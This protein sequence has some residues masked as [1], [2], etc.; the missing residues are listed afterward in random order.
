[1]ANSHEMHEMLFFKVKNIK[2]FKQLQF[3]TSPPPPP[4]IKY[5]QLYHFNNK[6]EEK[7]EYMI[8]NLF[9]DIQTQ[10]S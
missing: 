5:V 6:T 9:D 3:C 2:A 4:P 7:N 10:S 1:M 8:H